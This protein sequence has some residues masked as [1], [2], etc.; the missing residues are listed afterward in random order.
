[1]TREPMKPHALRFPDA[2]WKSAQKRASEGSSPRRVIVELNGRETVSE[3]VR[4]FLERW[5]R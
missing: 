1:M 4:K 5:T 3:A 2:L